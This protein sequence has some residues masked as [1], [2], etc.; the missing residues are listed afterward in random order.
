MPV[1]AASNYIYHAKLAIIT[2]LDFYSDKAFSTEIIP[3]RHKIRLSKVTLNNK[4]NSYECGLN[5]S[6]LNN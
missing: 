3:E 6:F 2:S 4:P 5:S 1:G